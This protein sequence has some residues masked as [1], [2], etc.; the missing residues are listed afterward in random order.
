MSLFSRSSNQAGKR[1]R[2][3]TRARH[4]PRLTLWTILLVLVVFFVWA[5][6]AEID[7]V[8]RAQGQVI[9]SSRT[10]IIQSTDGGVLQEILVKEGDQVSKG[11]LLVRLDATKAE[12]A[13]LESRAKVAALLAAQARLQAEIF[14][15][16]ARFPP[17]VGEY[18]QFR[19]NQML[20]LQKRRAAINEE[21]SALRGILS[22]AKRELDMNQPLLKT[23]DVSMA[24]VLKLQRQV[25]DLEARSPTS[26]TSISRR[27]RRNSARW[28]KRS[29]AWSRPWPSARTNWSTC[30]W[31]PRSA[32]W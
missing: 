3:G 23:G 5:A 27:P 21:I 11:Q 20:L 4:R 9:A 6:N 19:E 25:A 22:L 2:P 26:A 28:R 12:S 30:V 18:P 32:G 1:D 24:D 16:E 17:E 13:Y 15:G 14:G 31:S 10:Q 8:S 7:Q 29:P